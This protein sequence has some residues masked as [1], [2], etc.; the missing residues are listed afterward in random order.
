MATMY[1]VECFVDNDECYEE[2]FHAQK[3]LGVFHNLDEAIEAVKN[4]DV[5]SFTKSWPCEMERINDDK[6]N[7]G[8]S[9]TE[10]IVEA[11]DWGRSTWTYIVRIDEIN[12]DVIYYPD[13][14]FLL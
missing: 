7:S 1:K 6:I 4:L 9:W 2:Y 5:N 13:N 14:D 3:F 8:D 12:T 11:T 10:R